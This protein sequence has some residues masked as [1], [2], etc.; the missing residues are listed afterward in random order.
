M[1][2]NRGKP[3]INYYFLELTKSRSESKIDCGYSMLLFIYETTLTNQRH[4]VQIAFDTNLTLL[5]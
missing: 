4:I 1:A 2:K 3:D 5:K